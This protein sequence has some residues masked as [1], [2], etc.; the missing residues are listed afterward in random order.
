M[1]RC[2]KLSEK[3]GGGL[4]LYDVYYII[5]VIDVTAHPNVAPLMSSRGSQGFPLVFQ[6]RNCNEH[7]DRELDVVVESILTA[8]NL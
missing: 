4:F 3:I 5:D 1:P 7:T 6:S 8:T 2:F